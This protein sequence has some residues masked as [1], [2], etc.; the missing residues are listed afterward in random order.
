[1]SAIGVGLNID[2]D[3]R[4][5]RQLSGGSCGST[6]GVQILGLYRPR[7]EV[8]K[9]CLKKMKVTSGVGLGLGLGQGCCSILGM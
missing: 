5:T 9:L 4:K 3:G 7:I 1:M 8:E 6:Q 2:D